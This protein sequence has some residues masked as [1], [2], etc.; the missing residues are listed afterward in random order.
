M[1]TP[2]ISE[3]E[4]E[5]LEGQR[6]FA[7][8]DFNVPLKD[9]QITD[10]TRIRAALPTIRYLLDKGASVILASHLGRPKGKVNPAM[11]LEPVAARLAELL[12][13]DII[14][15][16]DCIGDG[17]SKLASDL[18]PGQVM[19]LEN[20]RFHA[21]EKKNEPEFAAALAALAD[22]YVN[23]A[24]GT[25]HRAHA[26]VVGVAE[27]FPV[28]RR[29]AGF[30][31]A[32]ELEFL[33]GALD[34]PKRPFVAV[35]GGAK[36]SDKLGVIKVL[37]KKADKILVGGAMAYTLLKA[38]GARVGASLVE[39][40]RV[41]EMARLLELSE[42]MRATVVLPHDHIVA[43][44]LDAAAGQEVGRDIPE[45]MMGL[46]I[47]PASVETFKLALKEAGTV[48]W[49]GPMG[50]FEREPF[51]HGT[52]ELARAL[53]QTD[54]VT[55]VGGGDSVAA[56]HKAGVA[57]KLS[58]ISTGGGASLELVEGQELPAIVALGR[59]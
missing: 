15:P 38:Q 23:D 25:S 58:H 6:V 56:V 41:Q 52:M 33:Q 21:A 51:A 34:K 27:R 53:A 49:N 37:L 7:R 57:E 59:R 2:L 18:E 20:L 31:V 39:E 43:N 14:F 54:A 9:G 40:D 55:I 50:V 4:A 11:S 35:L 36:V 12:E 3:L 46:D 42:G 16:E 32:R 13:R 45:G 19:L 48:F 8:V 5:V 1:G 28:G 22:T 17:V 26:S 24:F 10:D 47:G 44:S 29:A 30:L